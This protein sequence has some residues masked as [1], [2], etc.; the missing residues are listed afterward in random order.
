MRGHILFPGGRRWRA[1]QTHRRAARGTPAR[2]KS[3]DEVSR[4]EGTLNRLPPRYAAIAVQQVVGSLDAV[5]V[6]SLTPS[7][8]PEARRGRYYAVVEA[9]RHGAAMPVLA[10]WAIRAAAH[11]EDKCD[12]GGRRR[13]MAPALG[14]GWE[15]THQGRRHTLKAAICPLPP[16]FA[17]SSPVSGASL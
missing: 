12:T 17:P 3:F 8:Q 13:H 15:P 4:Q 6:A 5:K 16:L 7:F 9:M 2:L 10:T 11:E 14:P 1:E